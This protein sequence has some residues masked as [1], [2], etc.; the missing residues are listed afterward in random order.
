VS[1]KRAVAVARVTKDGNV[2]GQV[3]RSFDR[4]VDWQALATEVLTKET[5]P[6]LT[7]EVEPPR[8]SRKGW[9]LASAAVAVA[10]AG[11]GIAFGLSAKARAQAANRVPQVDQATYQSYATQAKV[12]GAVADGMFALAVVATGASV[13][14][15]ASSPSGV[16][17]AGV[18]HVSFAP[19]SGGAMAGLRG[20]F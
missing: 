15:Y 14:F 12:E 2:T 10:S 3:S 5:T 17:E 11:G 7:R 16:G 13:F 1:G 20:T 9:A 6:Q 18:L 4:N 8:P 19:T